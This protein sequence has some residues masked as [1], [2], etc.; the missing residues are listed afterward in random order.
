MLSRYDCASSWTHGACI[1]GRYR[2]GIHFLGAKMQSKANELTRATMKPVSGDYPAF[3][4]TRNTSHPYAYGFQHMADMPSHTHR[5][6][7]KNCLDEGCRVKG[8]R[9][10]SVSTQYE[11][12]WYERCA[13]PFTAPPGSVRPLAT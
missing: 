12:V 11:G 4:P 7:A 9:M 5:S 2:S 6:S 8:W 13:D 1:Y 10:E 3:T